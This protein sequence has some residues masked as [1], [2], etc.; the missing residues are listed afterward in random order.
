MRNGNDMIMRDVK[1]MP[2]SLANQR[3]FID[4]KHNQRDLVLACIC[5]L[6]GVPLAGFRLFEA[7]AIES[8]KLSLM[9]FAEV[10]IGGGLVGAAIYFYRR[11]LRS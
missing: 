8:Y 2:M 10:F 11:S 4:G 9:G 6:L 5:S 7:F 3:V 1:G